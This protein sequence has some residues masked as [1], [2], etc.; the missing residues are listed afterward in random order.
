[1]EQKNRVRG[2]EQG[3]GSK[4]QGA[5]SKGGSP[6]VLLLVAILLVACS[7]QPVTPTP[8]AIAPAN[9]IAAAPNPATA[10][11]APTPTLTPSLN[12]GHLV[13]WHS[14]AEADGDALATILATFRQAYP[15]L[16]ID[17]LF[18]A[19][20]DLPQSYAEAVQNGGG[21]DLILAPNVW[22]GAADAPAQTSGGFWHDRRERP[23]HYLRRTR[24]TPAE[25]VELW[26]ACCELAGLPL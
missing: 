10:T 6:L 11:P 16:K 23:T 26:R 18:V 3:A 1:M 9:P 2:R 5:R 14:W 25:R 8:Q 13:L 20:N 22:L 24:E 15:D 17:T 7:S 21:P 4:E 12:Q 19:Y